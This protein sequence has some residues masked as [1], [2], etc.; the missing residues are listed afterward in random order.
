MSC[1]AQRESKLICLPAL[2]TCYTRTVLTLMPPRISLARCSSNFWKSKTCC[3]F[4]SNQVPKLKCHIILFSH[5]FAQWLR[6]G[7][8]F[9]D[10]CWFLHLKGH[11]W[12]FLGFL[13]FGKEM[14][15]IAVVNV[16][17]CRNVHHSNIRTA[18]WLTAALLHSVNW[19]YWWKI[20]KN[21]FP[22]VW[23]LLLKVHP[24][25]FTIEDVSLQ[26]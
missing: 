19:C 20:Y 2:R 3:F 12:A 18:K 25:A 24:G 11:S 4:T 8:R 5:C 7:C 1:R 9:D 15:R 17:T 13:G 14:V 26:I 10:F 16:V 22:A 21:I 6:F 23:C